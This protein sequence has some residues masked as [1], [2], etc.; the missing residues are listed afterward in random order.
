MDRAA[1]GSPDRGDALVWTLT[2]LLIDHQAAPPCWRSRLLIR[3]C[4][5]LD[6]D[7]EKLRPIRRQCP[8]VL[9]VDLLRQ[10]R[11]APEG[12]MTRAPEQDL[13]K[14]VVNKDTCSS[15]RNK[16]GAV[17]ERPARTIGSENSL[18]VVPNAAV[19]I[20][21]PGYEAHFLHRGLVDTRPRKHI[22]DLSDLTF[23]LLPRGE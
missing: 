14:I 5:L 21:N 15:A 17:L 6:V 8:S 22:A 12:K 18:F 4:R 9:Q 20:T 3:S 19:D 13:M 16:R 2:D 11:L 7:R 10:S 1:M 23:R